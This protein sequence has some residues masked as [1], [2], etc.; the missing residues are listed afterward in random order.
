M[1]KCSL[2][3]DHVSILVTSVR[4]C[5]ILIAIQSEM[6]L[7]INDGHSIRSGA[8]I[9]MNIMKLISA[10]PNIKVLDI[11]VSRVG[12]ET[13]PLP[14][15][16]P[17]ITFP[18]LHEISIFSADVWNGTYTF[19]G[20][21]AEHLTMIDLVDEN[22]GQ[23]DAT[24]TTIPFPNLRMWN[25]NVNGMS[26]IQSANNVV[27]INGEELDAEPRDPTRG[28]GLLLS[29][30]ARLNLVTL[31]TL[32]LQLNVKYD[33]RQTEDIH[34]LSAI[35][36]TCPLLYK[37]DVMSTWEV[38]RPQ[39]NVWTQHGHSEG[40]MGNVVSLIGR[41]PNITVLG[42]HYVH[43]DLFREPKL[44]S[45]DIEEEHKWVKMFG[46]VCPNLRCCKFGK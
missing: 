23:P 7:G 5:H 24:F 15:F 2:S 3:Q 34:L 40:N 35:V 17:A 31:T 43:Y 6:I 4:M 20:K 30:I 10:C 1:A 22:N 32:Q 36:Q 46:E 28:V 27:A 45:Q 44:S 14:C 33:H 8:A 16:L 19:L 9:T 39:V 29:N 41:M 42:Y 13:G 18:Y 25:G 12:R 37:L 11:T 26:L 21:N 38:Y